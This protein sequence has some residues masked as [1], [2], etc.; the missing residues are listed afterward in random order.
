MAIDVILM[1]KAY[2]WTSIL[3]CLPKLGKL[4]S[5][6]ELQ[7]QN[8]ATSGTK[9]NASIVENKATWHTYAQR[10]NISIQSC[11]KMDRRHLLTDRSC[12]APWTILLSRAILYLY[13][14]TMCT[15]R[16]FLPDY[17]CLIG[18][19]CYLDT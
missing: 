10:R 2:Q 7:K 14:L 3:W 18:L 13:S 17:D 16:P 1:M 12:Y 8:L 9:D 19:M 15:T 5:V 6:A 11:A 4:L